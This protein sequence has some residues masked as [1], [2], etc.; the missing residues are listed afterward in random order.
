VLLDSL[1]YFFSALLCFGD[2][3]L[4]SFFS[5]FCGFRK[6]DTLSLLLIVIVMEALNRMIF[7]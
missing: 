5:S 7:A 1:L 2:D 4:T 3:T 6:G